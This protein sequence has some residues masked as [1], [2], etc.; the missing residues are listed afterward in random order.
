MKP[1]KKTKRKLYT[2][3][4]QE[5]PATQEFLRHW[6]DAGWKVDMYGDERKLVREKDGEVETM[7]IITE[8]FDVYVVGYYAQNPQKSTSTSKYIAFRQ[9]WNIELGEKPPDGLWMQNRHIF[10]DLKDYFKASDSITK[11]RVDNYKNAAG[12]IMRQGELEGHDILK[13]FFTDKRT[14]SGTDIDNEVHSLTSEEEKL[15]KNKE[16]SQTTFGDLIDDFVQS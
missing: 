11:D 12:K 2:Y 14:D 7:K 15:L 8:S 3:D 16:K 9:R 6:E 1:Q 13:G 4:L 10:A 5:M